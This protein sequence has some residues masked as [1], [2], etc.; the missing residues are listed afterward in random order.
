[1][2]PYIGFVLLRM[3]PR[4][5]W[6]II[7]RYDGSEIAHGFERTREGARLAARAHHKILIERCRHAQKK[8]PNH[9]Q[10]LITSNH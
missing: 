4:W 2:K 9:S 3:G 5:K 7:S 1:M 6:R 10:S 8:V